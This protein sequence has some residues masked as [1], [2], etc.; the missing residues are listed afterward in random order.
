[1]CCLGVWTMVKVRLSPWW[2]GANAV[3]APPKADSDF[4]IEIKGSSTNSGEKSEVVNVEEGGKI[5]LDEIVNQNRQISDLGV[6]EIEKDHD[7]DNVINT[8]LEKEVDENTQ[9]SKESLSVGGSGCDL[10][11]TQL[12]EKRGNTEGERISTGKATEMTS[13]KEKLNQW[14]M[15]SDDK[16]EAEEVLELQG[17]Q[18]KDQGKELVIKGKT[19]TILVGNRKET[20]IEIH[21]Q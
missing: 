4:W 12:G 5:L 1:M 20:L 14:V 10:D 3:A 7:E 2:F 15:L 11:P 9:P 19:I 17:L 6:E 21:K 18:G 13:R 8:R 16:I